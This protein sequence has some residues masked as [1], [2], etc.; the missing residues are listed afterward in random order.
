MPIVTIARE[1]GALSKAGEQ[2]LC[3]DLGL[4]CVDRTVL[5]EHFLKRGADRKLM[6]RFDERKPN[7]FDRLQNAVDIYALTL[8]LAVLTEAESG[9]AALI[10][11]GGN[12]LLHGLT[13]CLRLRF[14]AP[15]ELR[16][17][18]TA[19]EQKC[20]ADAA[21]KA[22]AASDQGRIGFCRHHYGRDWR[23]PAQYDLVINTEKTDMRTVAEFLR[24]LIAAAERQS[25]GPDRLRDELTAQRVR[26]ALF[27]AENL[28]V[29]FPEIGC[30]DGRITV[31]GS[32]SSDAAAE[33]VRQVISAVE[34]VR[35]VTDMLERIQPELP[36]RFE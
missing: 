28:P 17:K 9:N 2:A 10:G 27:D 16:V 18:R 13:G 24:P 25:G 33:R 36:R 22:I 14:T 19:E 8:K 30:S 11:R 20:T 23:D 31:H 12:F 21:A 5:E 32:V 1:M 34:G 15:L 7:F 35:E 29:Q 6:G 26:C 3:R 4:R